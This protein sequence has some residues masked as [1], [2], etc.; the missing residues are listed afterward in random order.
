MH[1]C[2]PS[3]L[4]PASAAATLVPTRVACGQSRGQGSAHACAPGSAGREGF[5]TMWCPLEP[6]R[7]ANKRS[8]ARTR[9]QVSVPRHMGHTCPVVAALPG[10]SGSCW[11]HAPLQGAVTSRSELMISSFLDVLGHVGS[12]RLRG[13]GCAP[14][15]GQLSCH[16]WLLEAMGRA[17]PENALELP[18]LLLPWLYGAQH[19]QAHSALTQANLLQQSSLLLPPLPPPWLPSAPHPTSPMLLLLPQLHRAGEGGDG[20]RVGPAPCGWHCQG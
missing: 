5:A 14:W 4:G 1:P 9:A 18:G 12:A 13:R 3:T 16:R 11:P 20:Q 19:S 6:M 10:P 7:D 2:E 8:G 17:G 15:C